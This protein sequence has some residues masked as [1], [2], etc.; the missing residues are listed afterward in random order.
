[1]LAQTTLGEPYTKLAAAEVLGRIAARKAELAG[2]VCILGHHYQC[3]EVF[4]L[5]DFTGD[6]LKL[7]QIAAA[8]SRH[9]TASSLEATVSARCSS[10]PDRR[11][12]SL[13]RSSFRSRKPK[14]S[15]SDGSRAWIRS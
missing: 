5:A 9:S 1:M 11:R 12:S 13:T 8:R 3:D 15:A 14:D 4:R 2:R 7:S 6:S 10:S